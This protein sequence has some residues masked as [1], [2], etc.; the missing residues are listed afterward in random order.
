MTIAYLWELHS[1]GP[2]LWE[3]AKSRAE[4]GL[5]TNKPLISVTD[6]VFQV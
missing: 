5:D 4:T 1:A 6:R 2:E 3:A